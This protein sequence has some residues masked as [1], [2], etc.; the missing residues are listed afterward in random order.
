LYN[1]EKSIELAEMSLEDSCCV[2]EVLRSIH[3]ALLCVQQNPED[4][5]T[6]AN[7]VLMLGGDG[8]LPHPNQ[9]GFFTERNKYGTDTFSSKNGRNSVNELSI[10]ALEAR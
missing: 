9:P 2:S 1:E 7:V 10:T 8:V 6:M 5:P 3:M 4:R